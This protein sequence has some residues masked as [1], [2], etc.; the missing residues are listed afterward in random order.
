M[1]RNARNGQRE[2]EQRTKREATEYHSR[3]ISKRG[4]ERERERERERETE[5]TNNSQ[6]RTRM[7]RNIGGGKIKLAAGEKKNNT[8]EQVNSVS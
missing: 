6:Q 7:R 5:D 4:G 1:L 2:K 3:I 8:V